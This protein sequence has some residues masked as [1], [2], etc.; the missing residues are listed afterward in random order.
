[1]FPFFCS[2]FKGYFFA[3]IFSAVRF[4]IVIMVLTSYLLTILIIPFLVNATP[5]ACFL[6]CINKLSQNCNND[7]SG[8]PCLCDL[9]V[10]MLQCGNAKCSPKDYN[11][12]KDHYL[13][14]CLYYKNPPKNHKSTHYSKIKRALL[15]SKTLPRVKPS[16]S[17]LSKSKSKSV[18]PHLK[19]SKVIPTQNPIAAISQILPEP[20]PELYPVLESV[21]DYSTPMVNTRKKTLLR[22]MIYTVIANPESVT[23][24]SANSE[25]TA[26]SAEEEGNDTEE[27]QKINTDIEEPI[28][29]CDNDDDDDNDEYH[30]ASDDI[31]DDVE[32]EYDNDE[33][34]TASI[35]IENDTECDNDLQYDI[36]DDAIKEASI[37]STVSFPYMISRKL[38]T[39]A[40]TREIF[41]PSDQEDSSESDEI[42]S[43]LTIAPSSTEDL[44]VITP[45]FTPSDI[46]VTSS[47]TLGLDIE[48][49]SEVTPSLKNKYDLPKQYK[50]FIKTNIMKNTKKFKLYYPPELLPTSVVMRPRHKRLKQIIPTK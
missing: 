38:R 4:E 44:P 48:N 41:T 30:T 5:P 43:T 27:F 8:I 2:F 22:Q 35:N 49:V 13:G 36:N 34:H 21:S 16:I 24:G 33:Y 1:M 26:V 10:M 37:V 31:E 29:T 50:S 28:L 18:K 6:A 7:Q 25:S 11:A 45:F 47:P 32:I 14:T 3:A 46:A 42:S 40:S 20:T 19:S 12:F 17:T 39:K 9:K 23:A 15:K